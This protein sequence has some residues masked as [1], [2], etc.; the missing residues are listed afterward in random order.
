MTAELQKRPSTPRAAPARART[1]ARSLIEYL[2]ARPLWVPRPIL[3]PAS[4]LSLHYETQLCDRHGRIERVLQRGRNTITNWGMDQ[5]ASQ[6]IYAL[7]N[8]LV[9]S[10]VPELK[11]T[12][13]SDATH[14]TCQT[15]SGQWLPGFSAPGSATVYASA[16][17][18]YTSINTLASYFTQLNTYDTA[19]Q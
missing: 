2:P 19:G 14:V 12:T 18:Y 4:S 11:I 15:P 9:L 6:S 16:T 7:I 17:I 10:N 13:Y 1:A 8:Y 5:L 3:L